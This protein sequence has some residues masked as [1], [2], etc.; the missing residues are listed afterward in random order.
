MLADREVCSPLSK[1]C[2]AWQMGVA[3]WH[4]DSELGLWSLMP[5]CCGYAMGRKSISLPF[6]CCDSF[7]GN[8]STSLLLSALHCVWLTAFMEQADILA[9]R[10]TPGLCLSAIKYVVTFS[11]QHAIPSCLWRGLLAPLGVTT[12]RA[13][14]CQPPPE[15]SN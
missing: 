15:P 12:E 13:A 10:G 1:S 9:L 4:G 7:Y 5:S 6:L 11:P 2:Q 14:V 3:G 8:V